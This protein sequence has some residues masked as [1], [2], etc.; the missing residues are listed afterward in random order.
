VVR[1]FLDDVSHTPEDA[2]L[3]G[4]TEFNH[5][6]HGDFF[7]SPRVPSAPRGSFFCL[8]ASLIAR[9]RKQKRPKANCFRAF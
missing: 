4:T 1:A 5:G 3:D 6:E 9:Q 7:S 8:I 2:T